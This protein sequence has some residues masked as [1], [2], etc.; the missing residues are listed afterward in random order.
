MKYLD[1]VSPVE[2]VTIFHQALS[3]ENWWIVDYLS[4][5]PGCIDVYHSCF[6]ENP[7]PP[8]QLQSN[9]RLKIARDLFEKY[10]RFYLPEEL[11]VVFALNNTSMIKPLLSLIIEFVC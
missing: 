1:W 2:N 6:T 8:E 10:R 11:T 4:S 9:G 7:L 5:L 3:D